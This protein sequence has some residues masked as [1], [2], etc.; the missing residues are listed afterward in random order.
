MGSGEDKNFGTCGM[1]KADPALRAKIERTR[2]VLDLRR[3]DVVF[4]TRLLFHRTLEVTDEGKRYYADLG[5][6]DLMRYSV[7]YVP[8]TARLP[9]GYN[10]FEWSLASNETNRGLALDDVAAND[11]GA[12]WS[13]MVWPTVESQVE[14]KLDAVAAERLARAKEKGVI[15]R[16][17]L[18]EAIQAFKQALEGTGRHESASG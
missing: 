15:E 3:G 6:D 9:S 17:T 7:R 16:K 4:A 18:G 10:P 5:K 13:P 11:G 2:V 12:L 1:D 8:G 14:E